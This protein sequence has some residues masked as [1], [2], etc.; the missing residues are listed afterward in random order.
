MLLKQENIEYCLNFFVYDFD[1]MWFCESTSVLSQLT[2]ASGLSMESTGWSKVR[3]T[4]HPLSV[5]A[6]LNKLTNLLINAMTD[7]DMWWGSDCKKSVPSSVFLCL[8]VN[9]HYCSEQNGDDGDAWFGDGQN[10]IFHLSLHFRLRTPI[11]EDSHLNSE[12]FV[13]VPFPSS[14]LSCPVNFYHISSFLF[15]LGS[16]VVALA[17]SN[18][19]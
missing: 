15:P 19:L 4:S 6:H 8:V 5:F 13:A 10:E 3:W 2:V 18:S 16:C 1:W 12:D 14:A 7:H 9:H 17:C 11:W